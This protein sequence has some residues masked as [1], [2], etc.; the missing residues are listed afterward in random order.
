MFSI[1]QQTVLIKKSIVSSF[2]LQQAYEGK[3]LYFI[4]A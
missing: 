3:S 4:L 2:K 1:T